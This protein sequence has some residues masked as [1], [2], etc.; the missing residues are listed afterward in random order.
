MR[1]GHIIIYCKEKK[2]TTFFANCTRGCRI[3]YANF[4]TKWRRFFF[5][6]TQAQGII[7]IWTLRDNPN[8][9]K[10]SSGHGD[11]EASLPRLQSIEILN[12]MNNVESHYFKISH[13]GF[14]S[15]MNL[16]LFA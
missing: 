15:A 3:S 7:V 10:K 6:P 8:E 4:L 13:A 11:R 2:R 16:P 12:V 5:Y 14:N 9:S 1:H